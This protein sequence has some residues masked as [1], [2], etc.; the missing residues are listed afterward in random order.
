MPTISSEDRR[1]LEP[2]DD[3]VDAKR[4]LPSDIR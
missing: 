3:E 1:R 2:F 4:Q